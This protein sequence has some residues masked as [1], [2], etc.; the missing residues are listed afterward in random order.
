MAITIT[1]PVDAVCGLY[2]GVPGTREYATAVK[3]EN[4]IMEPDFNPANPDRK[5]T[6]LR[7]GLIEADEAGALPLYR[8]CH[9]LETGKVAVQ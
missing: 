3:P 6:L 7:M 5:M 2:A 1:A 4:V 8:Y 9:T